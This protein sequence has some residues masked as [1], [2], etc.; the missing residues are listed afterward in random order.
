MKEYEG[1][2]RQAY[3]LGFSY[4]HQY[5]GCAQCT[6]AAIL[7]ALEIPNDHLFRAASGLASGGGLLCS[8]SCGGFSG[9]IMVISSLFGRRRSHFDDDND[10]KYSSFRMARDLQ[11]H[12]I[13]TY[14]SVICNEIHKNIFGRTY[15]LLDPADKE[16]FN[17]DG[18][19][20]DKCT[21]VVAHAAAWTTEI[22]LKE[23]EA[24]QWELTHIYDHQDLS[25]Q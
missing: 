18:A 15:N 2:I 10:F 21:S 16:Q 6:V 7:D 12:F 22:I 11:S 20:T 4:E 25:M 1:Y 3:E 9:G 8:G 14:R 13:H 23:L 17:K 19:H 24:K 5:R